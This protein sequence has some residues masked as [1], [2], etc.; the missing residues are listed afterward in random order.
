MA[1]IVLIVIISL[2]NMYR[3]MYTYTFQSPLADTE[4]GTIAP[5]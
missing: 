5:N 1:L 4:A 3:T 2:D